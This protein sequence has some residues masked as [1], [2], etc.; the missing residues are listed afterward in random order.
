MAVKTVQEGD[1]IGEWFQLARL[2][3]WVLNPKK[4]PEKQ[5]LELMA[6]IKRFGW[7]SPI[8]ARSKANPEVIAGHGRL[9]A[10]HRLGRTLVPVRFRPDLTEDEAHALALAE[11]K[12]AEMSVWDED[13]LGAALRQLD[14]AG[15]DLSLTGFG[16]TELDRHLRAD[17]PAEVE[18]SD[19]QEDCFYLRVTGPVGSQPEAIERFRTV[20]LPALRDAL[21]EGMPG[22]EISVGIEKK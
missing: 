16:G 11:N 14:S 8:I 4:H 17:V 2:V 21:A 7:G 22:L 18:T 3:G 1:P 5:I 19:N 15:F 13:P 9:L 12:L 6:K 10:A 20:V